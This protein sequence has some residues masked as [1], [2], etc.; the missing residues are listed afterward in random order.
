[1]ARQ[2][3][4]RMFETG[5]PI[6]VAILEAKLEHA[7]NHGDQLDVILG[8][9]LLGDPAL[10]VESGKSGFKILYLVIDNALLITWVDYQ[11]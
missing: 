10:V 5:K 11:W 9:N 8:W 7:E 3:Y 6:G 4:P 1:M 2:V